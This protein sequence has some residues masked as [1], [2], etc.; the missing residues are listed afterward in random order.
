MFK[1][2]L[3]LCVLSLALHLCPAMDAPFD[4]SKA[5]ELWKVPLPDLGPAPLVVGDLVISTYSPD[6]VLAVHLAD[7]SKAWEFSLGLADIAADKEAELRAALR[8]S[9]Y[10]MT[11]FEP[12]PVKG[13]MELMPRGAI[14]QY[15]A[16]QVL[17]DGKQVFAV[18][19]GGIA[20]CLDLMGKAL[21]HT[22]DEK[23]RPGRGLVF[24]QPALIEGL[25]LY[26]TEGGLVGRE[27]ATGA[28]RWITRFPK[29]EAPRPGIKNN[30]AWG[31]RTQ[32][33]PWKHQAKTYIVCADGSVFDLQGTCLTPTALS[34]LCNEVVPVMH[35]DRLI[36][37]CGE[38][39]DPYPQYFLAFDLA[40]SDKVVTR[41][42]AWTFPADNNAADIAKPTKPWS[43]AFT[44]AS[45]LLVGEELIALNSIPGAERI[46]LA[47][48]TNLP[49]PTKIPWSCPGHWIPPMPVV[50]GSSVVIAEHNG[51]IASYDLKTWSK[52]G[53][54][55][56]ADPKKEVFLLHGA[57]FFT[58]GKMILQTREALM[59]YTN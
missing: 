14:K 4:L 49:V 28:V 33:V 41:T 17:S 11:R 30:R 55:L 48:G 1:R 12:K 26:P 56:L 54:L 23:V 50:M 36:L 5:K 45:L 46:R 42:L 44:T 3:I 51:T 35:G 52:T 6:Q 18:S 24:G 19:P 58:G 40:L 9:V 31:H 38:G 29:T 43:R 39:H 10:P 37:N 21:W 13:Q 22:K 53:E 25:L 27:T 15:G 2:N 57:P 20:A 7:G 47:D 8:H 59:C 16:F 32:A 34:D